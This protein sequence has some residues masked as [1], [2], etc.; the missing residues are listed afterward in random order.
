MSISEITREPLIESQIKKTNFIYGVL[1]IIGAS[2]I[3]FS[4]PSIFAFNTLAVYQT[5]YIKHNG[6]D[7]YINYTMFYYPV[8][9]LFQSI[10]GLIAGII[11]SK[12][13]VHLT[14]FLGT[15][16][17]VLSGFIMYISNRFYLDMISM[18]LYGV[19][20]AILMFPS[21][22]NAC[23]YFMNHIGLVNGIVETFISLGS[24]FYTFIGEKMINPDEIPSDPEYHLYSGD[25]AIKVKSFILLQI[26]SYLGVYI[27]GEL[28]TKTY[29]ENNKEKFSITFIFRI[30][31]IKS[32]FNR[33]KEINELVSGTM[34]LGKSENDSNE[35]NNKD[36]KSNNDNNNEIYVKDENNN[37]IKDK[38]ITK[39]RKE[40]IKIVLKSWKFWRYNLISL[41]Q[42]PISDMVFAMYRGLGESYQVNQTALQ[43]IGTLTF[44]IEFILSF[45]FGIL[46]DYVNFK[47]LLFIMNIIGS[48]VGFTYY[49][50]FNSSFFFTFLTLLISVQ[51]AAYYSLKDYHLMKVFGTDIYIDLSG[52]V[53]L[54]TGICVIILTFVT[55]WV[56]EV[57]TDK[58]TAYKIMFPIFGG[59]NFMGVILGFFEDD[60]PFNYD[61]Y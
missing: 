60:E 9:L 38:K 59:F 30:N 31:E 7:A 23:K 3:N 61:D 21:T 45:V 40:K 4:Y 6:G 19:A 33:K 32:L 56:E 28:I 57:L 20:I 51:S 58:D 26:F 52:V 43:L 49:Y 54:F 37:I 34:E 27:I 17:F 16:L 44:I 35:D 53:C 24:T 55:Y 39:S 18:S 22:T 15:V 46:C 12:I 14:N 25:I 13:G 2:L 47:I 10:F 11:F 48:V 42:S 5:S 41:S 29:K 8:N 1:C 50:S 36:I